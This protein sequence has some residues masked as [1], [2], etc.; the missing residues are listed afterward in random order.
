MKKN[1]T[2]KTFICGAVLWMALP[3]YSATVKKVTLAPESALWLVGDSTLHP[4]TSR[5]TTL[6]L[7]AEMNTTASAA[8]STT[9]ALLQKG[10]LSQ[11]QLTIPVKGLKSKEAALDKNLYKALKEEKNPDILFRL[12][13]YDV[14]PSTVSA[15][16]ATLV[17]NGTLTV[18]G[19]DQTIV[20]K[21]DA[22]QEETG[23]HV[24]GHYPLL[25]SDYG[26][27]PPTMMMGTIRVKD[28]VV[29]HFDLHLI[30]TM[31]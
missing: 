18:A 15:M 31:N 3:V 4:F 2:I 20:L 24:E 25:M 29:I 11:L 6:N 9:H 27:K 22:V 7:S 19:K 28:Q 21:M 13:T 26:I 12:S 10:A 23:L 8:T 17:A 5:T 1:I 14:S 30:A 16:H